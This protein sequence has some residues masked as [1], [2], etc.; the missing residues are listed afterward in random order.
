MGLWAS[1]SGWASNGGPLANGTRRPVVGTSWPC[2]ECRMGTAND[3]GYGASP[4]AVGVQKLRFRSHRCHLVQENAIQ[5]AAPTPS[6]PLAGRLLTS[7]AA[8]G[9]RVAL[10]PDSTETKLAIP[11]TGFRLI[12]RR[13]QDSPFLGRSC[14]FF[15]GCYSP[16]IG[17]GPSCCR[18]SW[19]HRLLRADVS[20]IGLSLGLCRMGWRRWSPIC[21]PPSHRSLRWATSLHPPKSGELYESQTKR[22]LEGLTR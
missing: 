19:S 5:T 6:L 7:P 9:T 14:R 12:P 20:R 16:S 17:R 1:H 10:F 3:P 13:K 8:G 21:S 2:A 11:V 4:S 22:L 18:Y 15:H